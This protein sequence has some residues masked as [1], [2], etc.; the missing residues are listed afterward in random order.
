MGLHEIKK[1]QHNKRIGH[2]IEQ[3]A[4]TMR[5]NLYQPYI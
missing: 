1:L 3:A 2:Q 5:E 4:Y